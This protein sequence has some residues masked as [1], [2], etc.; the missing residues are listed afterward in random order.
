M[1]RINYNIR[2]DHI[3]YDIIYSLTTALCFIKRFFRL[4]R[5]P[6]SNAF[7]YIIITS[8]SDYI[9]FIFIFVKCSSSKRKLTKIGFQRNE[10]VLFRVQ[11]SKVLYKNSWKLRQ[12]VGVMMPCI[13]WKVIYCDFFCIS[14]WVATQTFFRWAKTIFFFR[15]HPLSQ[16]R[17]FFL[18]D[19]NRDCLV[20]IILRR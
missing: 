7:V 10:T 3:I 14:N 9:N 4:L 20:L 6:I 8:G 16:N 11:V 5:R 2:N 13:V 19:V 1:Y 12:F 18:S 15:H 17:N